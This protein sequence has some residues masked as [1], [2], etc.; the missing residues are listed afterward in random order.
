MTLYRFVGSSISK[1]IF[2]IL[3]ISIIPYLIFYMYVQ[4]FSF[5]YGKK[6][7]QSARGKE[8]KCE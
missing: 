1:L 8:M 3:V 2:I 4:S 7:N 5:I 6:K